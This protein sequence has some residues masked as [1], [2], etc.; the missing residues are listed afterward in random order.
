MN[1]KKIF[2]GA[3]LAVAILI[4]FVAVYTARTPQRPLIL[5]EMDELVVAVPKDLPGLFDNDGE[6]FGYQYDLLEAYADASELSLRIVTVSD[7]RS[8]ARKLSHGKADMALAISRDL[9]KQ[10]AGLSVYSTAFAVVGRRADA[11]GTGRKQD[12]VSVSDILKDKKV[13]ISQGFKS[14]KAYGALLDSMKG[15]DVFVSSDECIDMAKDIAAGKYDYYVCEKS[16][17]QL[18]CALNWNIRKVHELDESVQVSAIF[19]G[20]ISGL[21]T[22]FGEWLDEYRRTNEFAAL[23]YR[24]FEK[25]A[26]ERLADASNHSVGVIS[27]FDH[28]MREVG[29]REGADW[30]LMAAIA[31]CESRFKPNVVSNRGAKGLMQIMPVVARQFGVPDEEVMDPEVNI[32][33]AVKLL[34]E[35]ESMM[36]I[37]DGTSY[38]DRM[39]LVL[40][41]YNCGVGHVADA[42]RLAAKYGMNSNSWDD[43][44]HFLTQKSKPEYY[45][46]EVVRNGIFRGSEQT[47]GFVKS[48]MRR[49][50]S[51]CTLALK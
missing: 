12:S 50:S 44:A 49:Y 33:L 41:S 47:L 45:G 22:D 48:V 20:H 39:S 14:S 17:A 7:A 32:T 46:D 19:G 15:S 11:S 10:Q 43:V 24:Y 27:P 9:P 30:R 8:A 29:E 6:M 34:N 1:D 26:T 18:M 31:Y 35:I 2:S 37:P 51:Y 42:R 21:E 4:T 25:G 40:A 23:T 3:A 28:V 36:Q 16:E 38:N 13:V 5:A